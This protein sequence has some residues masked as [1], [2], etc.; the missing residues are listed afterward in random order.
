MAEVLS[1]ASLVSFL[2]ALLSA[3]LAVIAYFAQDIRGVRRE[4]KGKAPQDLAVSRRRKGG[5]PAPPRPQ[6][7][8]PT[9]IEDEAVTTLENGQVAFDPLV[10]FYEPGTELADEVETV[11]VNETPTTLEPPGGEAGRGG[12]APD[13]R[14][15]APGEETTEL[16]PQ[17]GQFVL[18]CDILLTDRNSALYE[19]I[20]Q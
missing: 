6:R 12:P 16:S 13:G 20:S 8:R 1:M 11:A 2:L 15:A 5:K 19:L 10:D 9:V 14:R 18:Q 4:L 3:A 17:E 7:E